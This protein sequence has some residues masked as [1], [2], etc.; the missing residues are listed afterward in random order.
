[1]L[2]T[3][4]SGYVGHFVVDALLRHGVFF[5]YGTRNRQSAGAVPTTARSVSL[6]MDGTDPKSVAAAVKTSQPDVVINCMAIPYPA[7]CEKDPAAAEKLNV[8]TPL[9]DAMQEFC[10]EALLVHLST[11]MVYG[12]NTDAPHAESAEC[13]P[14]NVYGSTKLQG[15]NLI[16]ERWPNHIILRS[17]AI[18][19]P[20]PT[21]RACSKSSTFL[22]MVRHTRSAHA[23]HQNRL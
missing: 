18:Y 12:S 11:D 9:V 5:V 15:E 17:S 8:P 22:Q 23:G 10:P 7:A 1:M 16:R 6:T 21:D 14:V 4:A 2:V 3:G 20:V 13:K 19:G